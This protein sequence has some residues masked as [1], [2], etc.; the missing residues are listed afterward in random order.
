MQGREGRADAA[1][2]WWLPS[3]ELERRRAQIQRNSPADHSHTSPL[4][5]GQTRDLAWKASG[6]VGASDGACKDGSGDGNGLD[7]IHGADRGD[8][9]NDAS[10][11]VRASTAA[12]RLDDNGKSNAAPVVAAS[13]E[14]A[15]RD[16]EPEAS[17][18][19][20]D[21]NADRYAS[22]DQADVKDVGDVNGHDEVEAAV[23]S[24]GSLSSGWTY[25]LSN[26]LAPE[27]ASRWVFGRFL[28]ARSL[29][30]Y[31]GCSCVG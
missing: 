19:F 9:C 5:H 7:D 20:V 16:S 18:K 24:V 27:P 11:L 28:D 13:D 25:L 29:A 23:R 15:G 21:Q 1:A 31:A 8:S 14:N 26:A 12:R 10:L 4:T 17:P 22:G 6:R 30:A 2:F 3:H